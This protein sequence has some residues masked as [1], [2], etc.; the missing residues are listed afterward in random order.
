MPGRYL[1][2]F[3][4]FAQMNPERY[5]LQGT[6]PLSPLPPR[7]Q[8]R[9]VRN[10]VSQYT[11]G[12]CSQTLTA[13]KTTQDSE[14]NLDFLFYFNTHSY[15]FTFVVHVK[16]TLGNMDHA[17]EPIQTKKEPLRIIRTCIE[18]FLAKSA[19]LVWIK[20]FFKICTL[21]WLINL[22]DCSEC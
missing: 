12:A 20:L 6:P 16:W 21:L 7:R 8:K 3:W 10:E 13:E 5:L 17:N 15:V 2:T 22:I 1:Q 14:L 4:R 9:K 18:P 19:L 11:Y